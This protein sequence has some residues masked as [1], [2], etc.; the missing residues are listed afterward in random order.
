M[1]AF[2]EANFSDLANEP[3]LLGN[4]LNHSSIAKGS[5]NKALSTTTASLSIAGTLAIFAT[6]WMWPDLRTNSRRMIVFISVG[7]FLVAGANIV[8]LWGTSPGPSVGCRIQAAVGA[9][10]LL[11][12]FFWTV[13]LSLYFYLIICRGI[14][15]EREKRVLR[16]FHVTALG[17]PLTIAMICLA[18]EGFG[19]A[20]N[21]CSSGWCWISN[22]QAWWMMVLWMCVTGKAWEMIA[23]ITIPIFYVLVK[24]HIRRQ[25][26]AG[27]LPGSPFI[28][29][30]SVEVAKRADQK[31]ILIPVVFILVHIW[32]TIRFFRFLA[33][34]PDCQNTGPS[35]A[36]QVLVILQVTV[37]PFYLMCKA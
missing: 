7:D 11:F 34:L 2:F 16:L 26:S 25:V 6:F 31:L 24:T 8:G 28:T 12:S 9:I 18:L 21:V 23:Y 14:S 1:D 35:H 30:R 33:C 36:L 37:G 27:F 17:I 19:Y 4:T 3:T 29:V 13:Y 5:L 22:D 32:G 20:G 15:L 10:A